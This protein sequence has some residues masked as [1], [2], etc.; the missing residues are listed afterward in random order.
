MITSD[1]KEGEFKKDLLT[2]PKN[3][4]RFHNLLTNKNGQII[5]DSIQ[6]DAD[7]LK[8][9]NGTSSSKRPKTQQ[10]SNFSNQ[11][12]EIAEKTPNFH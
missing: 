12:L 10:R 6:T 4:G 7:S 2:A 5:V 8:E 9:D 1:P 3:K 11:R